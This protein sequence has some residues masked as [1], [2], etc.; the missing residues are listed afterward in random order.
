MTL[1]LLAYVNV[2][3]YA[4]FKGVVK[5]KRFSSLSQM[6]EDLLRGTVA[7]IGRLLKPNT[8]AGA[9]YGVAAIASAV[10]SVVLLTNV[11]FVTVCAWLHS[12]VLARA[13]SS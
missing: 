8:W 10:A 7:T 5:S 4:V 3:Q 6:A 2:V 12:W 11:S 9:L 13:G 1:A